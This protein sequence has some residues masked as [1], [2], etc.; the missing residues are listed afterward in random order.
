MHNLLED[1]LLR[2]RLADGTVERFS[3]PTLYVALREDRVADFPSL[4]PH[5]RHAWHAFLAQ[6]AAIAVHRRPGTAIPES[7]GAWGAALRALTSDFPEDEP[8]R[9]VVE[10]SGKP[11]FMQCPAPDGLDAYRKRGT[12]PSTH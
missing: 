3:L 6:L 12:L 5:Q 4:R 1:R 2:A 9:L 11:A 8:W 7:A 10:D